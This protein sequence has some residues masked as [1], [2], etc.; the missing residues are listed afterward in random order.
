MPRIGGEAPARCARAAPAS[1]PVTCSVPP[2]GVTWS[3]PGRARSAAASVA[4]SGPVTAHAT[5]FAL[6][7]D[8]GRGAGGEQPAFEDVREPVAALGLVHV[9]RRDEHRDAL[10][11]R[12]RGSGPRSRGAPSGRR[13]P[14]ARR[15][16][17]AAGWCSMQAASDRRCFQPP[18]SWPAS[19]S[20]RAPKVRARRSPR[21]T[22]LRAVRHA[23]HPRHEIEVL[24]DGEVF[25]QR[26]AL[27][28]VADLALDRVGLADHVE[29]EAGAAAAVRRRAGR[30][31]SGSTSS[32]R[33]RWDRESRRS[34]RAAPAA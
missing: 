29:A 9:V 26:K 18:D 20:R 25:P 23:V 2:N 16:A 33:C 4:R 31:A 10:R 17:A 1:C 32:C 6:R 8:L 13:P 7:H 27:R 24:A 5:S 15:A 28:H 11:R 34:R 14:S 21:R 30:T 3:T 19:W 22:T 12:A